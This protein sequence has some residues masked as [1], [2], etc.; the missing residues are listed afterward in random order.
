[1]STEGHRVRYKKWPAVLSGYIAQHLGECG[2]VA[3]ADMERYGDLGLWDSFLAS[4][5]RIFF[6]SDMS[7]SLFP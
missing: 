3:L 2:D 7:A 6:L 4:I 1:M 5:K